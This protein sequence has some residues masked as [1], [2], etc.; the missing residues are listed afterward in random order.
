M[1]TYKVALNNTTRR[2]G[3]VGEGHQVLVYPLVESYLDSYA[4]N[5]ASSPSFVLTERKIGRYKS[6]FKKIEEKNH[7]L[8]VLIQRSQALQL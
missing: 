4:R 1:Q 3:I 6:F 8:M 5:R 7:N 2:V